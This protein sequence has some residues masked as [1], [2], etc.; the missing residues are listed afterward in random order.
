VEEVMLTNHDQYRRAR[1]VVN[2]L[3]KRL[4]GGSAT[5][6]DRKRYHAGVDHC[7]I[8]EWAEEGKNPSEPP[9]RAKKTNRLPPPVRSHVRKKPDE[10][11]RRGSA[12]GELPSLTRRG[13]PFSL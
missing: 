2:H 3:E 10:D 4:K 9:A 1:A 11:T 5:E 13:G 7:L 6:E 8:F 12:Y